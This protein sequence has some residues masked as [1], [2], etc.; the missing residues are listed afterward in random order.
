MVGKGIGLQ[1]NSATFYHMAVTTSE[2]L[3]KHAQVTCARQVRHVEVQ[4]RRVS[5][6]REDVCLRA[7]D[8][9]PADRLVEVQ[10]HEG[11]QGHKVK[12]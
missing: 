4:V 7:N 2:L 12:Q 6:K 1:Q 10:G 3:A 5:Q 8:L 9:G 11:L